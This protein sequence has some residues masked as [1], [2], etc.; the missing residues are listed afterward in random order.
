M[1]PVIK[2]VTAR[3]QELND[4]LLV[5]VIECCND[6]LTAADLEDNGVI[7]RFYIRHLFEIYASQVDDPAAVRQFYENLATWVNQILIEK[8]NQ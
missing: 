7:I 2:N 6:K 4:Q 1:N 8:T 5:Q 3:A